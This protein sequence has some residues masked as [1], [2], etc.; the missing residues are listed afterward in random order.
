MAEIRNRVLFSL[1]AEKPIPKDW[2]GKS[3]VEIIFGLIEAEDERNWI[4]DAAT[5]ENLSLKQVPMKATE[6]AAF[7]RQRALVK[8]GEVVHFVLPNCVQFHVLV[9]GVWLLGGVASLADPSLSELV[10]Q[11]QLEDTKAALVI[12]E[13]KSLVKI[14]SHFPSEKIVTIDEIFSAKPLHSA[15]PAADAYFPTLRNPRNNETM[16]IFW[17]S[18]TTGAPKGIGHGANFLLRSLVKSSFSASTLLQTTCFFHTGGFFAP[19][20]GG[21]YNGFRIVFR[22]ANECITAESLMENVEEF[23]PSVIVCGSHHAAQLSTCQNFQTYDLSSVLIVAPMGSALHPS[24]IQDLKL[25]FKNMLPVT[26]L[27]ISLS[28]KFSSFL[29]QSKGCSLILW[30]E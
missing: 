30:N 2:V 6:V 9:F 11:R 16:V 15:I 18:G 13:R 27:S 8:R 20:D 12:C 29:Q 19:I 23:K 21:I 28:D 17:S 1:T 25:R 4:T 7:L 14:K 5:K 3:F 22:N 10:L 24:A 26:S